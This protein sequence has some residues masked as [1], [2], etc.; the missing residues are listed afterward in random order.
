M[1]SGSLAPFVGDDI[2]SLT[3]ARYRILFASVCVAVPLCL[4]PIRDTSLFSALH[5]LAENLSLSLSL[6]LSLALKVDCVGNII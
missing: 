2:A 6:S 5:S 1:V 4:S 3:V